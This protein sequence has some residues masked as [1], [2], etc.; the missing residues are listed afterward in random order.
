MNLSVTFRHMEATDALKE[1]VRER[2]EKLKRYF[3]G[4]ASAHVV[5][6][7]ERGYQHLAD[8]NIALANGIALKGR[9]QTEDMYSSIDLAL[10][11]IE[12]QVRKYK[13]R[14]RDHKPHHGPEVPIRA[15]VLSAD[16]LADPAQ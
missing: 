1:Y 8:I 13:E 4:P 14:I 16:S 10:A 12:R 7:T 5:L 11:K 15:F 6:S 2:L 3:G 9:E